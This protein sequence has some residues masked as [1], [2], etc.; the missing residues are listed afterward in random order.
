[1]F[2]SEFAPRFDAAF[3]ADGSGLPATPAAL[4]VAVSQLFTPPERVSVQKYIYTYVHMWSGARGVTPAVIDFLYTER[5]RLQLSTGL[6]YLDVALEAT[7]VI[8]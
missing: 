6:S 8:A 1:V 7:D 5:C 4:D 2:A 3:G